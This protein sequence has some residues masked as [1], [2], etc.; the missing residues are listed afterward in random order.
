M[1]TKSEDMFKLLLSRGA[2]PNASSSGAAGEPGLTILHAV[3]GIDWAEGVRLLVANGAEVDPARDIGI[4]PMM[5]AAGGGSEASL[6]ALADL[7]ADIDAC[8]DEGD[9]VL[10]YASSK[11]HRSTV[12]RLIQ[13]GADCDT[14]PGDS[15][16]T[17]LTIAAQMASPIGQ[18][19]Q[20]V[21]SSEFTR[22]AIQLIRA[23]ADPGPMYDAGLVLVRERETG[24]ETAPRGSVTSLVAADHRWTIAYMT[25]ERRAQ[26]PWVEAGPRQHANPGY[27][28]LREDEPDTYTFAPRGG[29]P[30]RADGRLSEMSA[31]VQALRTEYDFRG[32]LSTS[33]ARCP[34]DWDGRLA[35]AVASK[36]QGHFYDSAAK[37]VQLSRDSGVV[38]VQ[39]LLALYKTVASAGDVVLAYR[40]LS[41][42]ERIVGNES[43]TSDHGARMIGAV[44]SEHALLAYLR[45]INGNASYELPRAYPEILEDWREYEQ[46]VRDT[47]SKLKKIDRGGCYIATAVY[48][49][50]EAPSVLT[51]RRFRDRF[52][53]QSRMGR[54][55]IGIYYA[56]SPSIARHL[57]GA[58][59]LNRSTR[60]ALDALVRAL[61]RRG[62]GS[63]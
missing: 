33:T 19:S 3:A 24:R 17:P 32:P 51:L 45:D 46:L 34:A 37:Y 41:D 9:S 36:R 26:A 43:Q 23:G 8:D 22:I 2:D 18:R 14:E 55:G 44:E 42:I 10:F 49:S 61:D 11:G 5:L 56:V 4:T 58:S 39:L 35:Q 53:A 6:A 20:D 29:I 1:G 15:G 40:L 59:A 47:I 28:T 27:A 7:G 25:P 63:E 48:G 52:L 60:I 21:P 31:L 62:Y 57:A 30:Y 12:E 54:V 38:Y 50:Y 13:L 16:H